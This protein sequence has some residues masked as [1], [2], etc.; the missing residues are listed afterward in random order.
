MEESKGDNDGVSCEDVC[1]PSGTFDATRSLRKPTKNKRFRL[2]AHNPLA[3][4][5]SAVTLYPAAQSAFTMM[6]KVSFIPANPGTF[7]SKNPFGFD[8]SNMR[9]ICRNN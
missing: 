8:S 7:S 3:E 9:T 1:G 6:F 4:H 5:I 2:V